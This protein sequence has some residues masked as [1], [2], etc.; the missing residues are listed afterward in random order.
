MG[1]GIPG[2]ATSTIS[3]GKRKA[4]AFKSENQQNKNVHIAQLPGDSA[5]N[6]T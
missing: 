5:G 3:T 2:S 6:R 4:K 1:E